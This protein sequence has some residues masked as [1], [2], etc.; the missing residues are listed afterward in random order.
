M[1]DPTIDRDLAY[2]DR[3]TN[4]LESNINEEVDRTVADELTLDTERQFLVLDVTD[5][6]Y[7]ELFSSVYLGAALLYAPNS[8]GVLW[9]LWK[10]ATVDRF[11][12]A[13]RSCVAS[14]GGGGTGGNPEKPVTPGLENR[15]MLAD[16]YVCDADHAFGLARAIVE[17]IHAATLEFFEQIELA[18]N[19]LELALEIND[20]IPIVSVASTA[21]E[22]LAW[23]QETIAEIYVAAWSDT[24]RDD[25]ACDLMCLILEDCTLSYGDV[26]GLYVE[27]ISGLPSLIDAD[28]LE[29]MDWLFQITPGT[30]EAT[31]KVAGL[32]GLIAM[33]FGGKFLSLFELGIYSF[34]MVVKL[35]AD[36]SSDEHG[37]LCDECPGH[38]TIDIDFTVDNGGFVAYATGADPGLIHG[39]Y[40]AGVGWIQTRPTGA[41]HTGVSIKRLIGVDCTVTYVKIIYNLE[42]GGHWAG[43]PN[44]RNGVF[45]VS[46]AEG[47]IEASMLSLA[48]EGGT[49]K[50][51][52][53][54][55]TKVMVIVE[56]G[57]INMRVYSDRIFD[58]GDGPEYGTATITFMG[59]AGTGTKPEWGV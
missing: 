46:S 30:N 43:T 15:D 54:V 47:T 38:W 16:D 49:D 41:T 45:A 56:D 10:A 11:C 55:G 21:G 5:L 59:I 53:Q 32:V 50:E 28:F 17:A 29:W 6:E 4:F 27:G 1:V 52:S 58:G 39:T 23:V 35:A 20:N 34:D 26:F 9:H 8:D 33:R 18:T 51:R 2:K 13:V 3:S 44:S 48:D 36:E 37:I 42:L 22:V 31:V 24:T 12:D 40:S 57:V 25:I 19:P 14:G 7:T